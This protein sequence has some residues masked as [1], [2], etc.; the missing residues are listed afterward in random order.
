MFRSMF[1][2]LSRA[3]R[4]I[5]S[6][7]GLGAE[8]FTQ[9]FLKVGAHHAHGADHVALGQADQHVAYADFVTLSGVILIEG[10]AKQALGI[11][12]QACASGGQSVPGPR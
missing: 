11:N 4:V 6:C 2:I 9:A 5:S 12:L 8:D 3:S 1:R 7:S 10:A